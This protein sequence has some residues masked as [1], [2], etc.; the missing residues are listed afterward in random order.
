MGFDSI[1]VAVKGIKLARKIDENAKKENGCSSIIFFL[2]KKLRKISQTIT[3]ITQ[4][5]KFCQEGKKNISPIIESTTTKSIYLV[6]DCKALPFLRIFRL[7]VIFLR[8]FQHSLNSFFVRI[9]RGFT[10]LYSS[11]NYLPAFFFVI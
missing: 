10:S 5:A 9:S 11:F 3:V 2:K 7:S 8:G 1:N 4:P 6:T